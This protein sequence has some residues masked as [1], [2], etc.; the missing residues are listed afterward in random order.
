MNHKFYNQNIE[1][2]LSASHYTEKWEQGTIGKLH[3]QTNGAIYIREIPHQNRHAA[4]AWRVVDARFSSE[5]TTMTYFRAFGLNG[6]MLP[7]ASFGINFGSV[8]DKINLAGFKFRPEFENRYYVPV[9][10]KFHTPNT[11]G[12]VV[13]V[14]DK[15]NPSEGLAFG[16]SKQGK[17]HQALIV[18]FRLF[19]LGDAYPND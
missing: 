6:K 5:D 8:P 7:E 2:P 17:Q 3:A 13:Q 10:N 19:E 16:L 14:L 12:Y 18:S 4:H 1:K 9:E 15:D 11:G